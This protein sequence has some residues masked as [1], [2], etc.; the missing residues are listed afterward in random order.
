MA[1]DVN[2]MGLDLQLEERE[3]REPRAK[4]EARAPNLSETER[5][6]SMIGGGA[7]IMYG[8]SK[9]SFGGLLLAA[10]GGGFVV[11]GKTAHC[12]VY[13]RMGISTKEPVGTELMLEASA[14]IYRSPEEVYRFYRDFDNLPRFMKHLESVTPLGGG[15][16]RWVMR[17][18]AGKVIEWDAQIVEEREYELIRWRSLEGADIQHHGQ[19]RFEKAP[20]D[21]GTEVHVMWKYQPPGAGLG[22]IIGKLAQIY[23]STTLKEELYRMKQILEA[24]EIATT[25]GQPS[26]REELAPAELASPNVEPDK[27]PGTA[28]G[29]YEEQQTLH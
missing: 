8:L 22:A 21:R 14:T 2:D 29:A 7:L 6:T 11:R 4:R 15:R 5:W 25:E 26:G 24:G 19:V 16:S 17:L 18:P 13:K 27:I 28:E 1:I 9:K 3:L 23:T 10:I 12:P 20:G